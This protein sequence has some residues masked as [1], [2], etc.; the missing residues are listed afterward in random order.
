MSSRISEVVACRY[1]LVTFCYPNYRCLE[2]P[3]IAYTSSIR[4]YNYNVI[5]WR[6]PPSAEHFSACG[7]SSRRTCPMRN[8]PFSL[9]PPS[10]TQH[11]TTRTFLA[12]TVSHQTALIVIVTYNISPLPQSGYYNA[13]ANPSQSY[14][15]YPPNS[16]SSQAIAANEPIEEIK[17]TRALAAEPIDAL[18]R[19]RERQRLRRVEL[20]QAILEKVENEHRESIIRGAAPQPS[21]ITHNPIVR[22][23]MVISISYTVGLEYDIDLLQASTSSR[24]HTLRQIDE[25][26]DTSSRLNLAAAPT[27]PKIKN[28]I[29]PIVPANAGL[30]SRCVPTSASS[31]NASSPPPSYGEGQCQL[32]VF[33]APSQGFGQP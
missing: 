2:I 1:D 17:R 20:E 25:L 30:D 18:A 29:L 24:K 28:R 21:E 27:H 23:F 16:G 22:N 11:Y 32:P 6:Y 7:A 19:F 15:S 26:T 12:T 33:I 5:S 9:T 10:P 14:Q 4:K 3:H 8:I 31:Q 13:Y